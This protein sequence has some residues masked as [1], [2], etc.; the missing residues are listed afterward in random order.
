MPFPP[1]RNQETES[2]GTDDSYQ[3]DVPIPA[4]VPVS[5]P[6]KNAKNALNNTLAQSKTTVKDADQNASS[7]SESESEYS[8]SDYDTTDTESYAGYDDAL[9]QYLQADGRS[10]TSVLADIHSVLL[11]IAASLK[12]R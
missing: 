11:D 12:S 3:Y 10:I 7:E 2:V 9:K 1:T 8:D 5:V 4:P 6:V